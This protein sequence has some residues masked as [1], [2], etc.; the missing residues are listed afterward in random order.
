MKNFGLKIV[1]SG[2]FISIITVK[3]ICQK[4]YLI[5]TQDSAYPLFT[6]IDTSWLR[7]YDK[8]FSWENF[9]KTPSAGLKKVHDLR[10]KLEPYAMQ[11]DPLGEFLYAKTFDL[12][13]FGMGRPDERKI[14][15]AYYTKAADKNLAEA[16]SFLYHLYR[17]GLMDIT[18]DIEKA[19][20]YLNN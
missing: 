11:G 17:Y 1:L 2:L 14:A 5:S 12:Y 4:K 20:R 13:E 16:E 19:L 15:L 9:M 8:V 18:I 6:A 10:K 3:G 7:D